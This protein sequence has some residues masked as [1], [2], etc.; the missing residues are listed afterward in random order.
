MQGRPRRDKRKETLSQA[1]SNRRCQSDPPPWNTRPSPQQSLLVL[2][3]RV[4]TAPAPVP[5][6]SIK[7]QNTPPAPHLPA[8][9]PLPLSPS[10]V[11]RPYPRP[12]SCPSPWPSRPDP[13]P[14]L[15]G[16]GPLT[17]PV[18]PSFSSL[19][20]D[21][22]QKKKTCAHKIKQ[23]GSIH[24]PK[25]GIHNRGAFSDNFSSR[26]WRKKVVGEEEG[27]AEPCCHFVSLTSC[28]RSLQEYH[29]LF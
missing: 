24:T 28:V 7:T 12:P 11:A 18:F 17:R 1:E 10:P 2:L 21:D 22:R 29:T 27:R 19:L 25:H 26:L 9:P 4:S 13:G 8:P 15:E 14:G 6:H 20:W 3:T 16:S 23:P 5:C